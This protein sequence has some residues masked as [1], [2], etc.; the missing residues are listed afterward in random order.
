MRSEPS[1]SP[2]ASG[3]PDVLAP[4]LVGWFMYLD[5]HKQQNKDGLIFL[6][7]GPIMKANG[8]IHLSQLTLNY[9]KLSNLQDILNIDLGT[10]I[11]IMQYADEDMEA[12]KSGRFIL[13]HQS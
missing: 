9:L 12:V 4:V 3:T 7:Y 5:Q 13:P 10:A 2:A 11:L 6:P 1:P 8:F